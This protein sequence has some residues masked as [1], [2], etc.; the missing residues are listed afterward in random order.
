MIDAE[1]LTEYYITS[2]VIGVETDFFVRESNVDTYVQCEVLGITE[3]DEVSFLDELLFEQ[4]PYRDKK[5]FIDK[6][7][8]DYEKY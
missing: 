2:E 4:D 1:K 6:F 3:E 5:P 7:M 8:M